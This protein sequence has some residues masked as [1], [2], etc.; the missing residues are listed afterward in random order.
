MKSLPDIKMLNAMRKV[1]IRGAQKV[2][3]PP[4]MIPDHGFALP[5]DTR[6]GGSIYFRSGTQDRIEP[7]VTNARPDLAEDV[8][9]NTRQRIRSAFF[10]DQLQLV[11]GAQMTATEVMQRTEENLRLM[12]PILGRLNDE[13][14]RPII[15]RL[16]GIMLRNNKFAPIPDSLRGKNL[17]IEYVSQIAKA[18]RSSEAD[19]LLRVIQTT[20][21]LIEASPDIMDNFDGDAVLRHNAKIFGLPEEMLRDP[22][23]V[24]QVRKQRQE[25]AQDAQEAA[26]QNQEAD[27]TQKLATAQSKAP[28]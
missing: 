27:T 11:Q 18:Q 19:T 2:V 6:P 23:D 1:Q 26:L 13:L 3:D 21:P 22:A 14:L 25:D 5:L 24:G 8:M 9:E 20:A 7:L 17:K 4:L 28:Q 15:D 10:I 16:F 12:G